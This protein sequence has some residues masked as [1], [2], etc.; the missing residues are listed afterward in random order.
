M[1]SVYIVQDLDGRLRYRHML[2]Y[3]VLNIIV[4]MRETDECSIKHFNVFGAYTMR[5]Y[6]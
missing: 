4:F 6:R 5:L 3:V 1:Y 2:K